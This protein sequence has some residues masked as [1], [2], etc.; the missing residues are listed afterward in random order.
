[1]K[2]SILEYHSEKKNSV[3]YDTRVED[4]VMFTA[5]VQ[6]TA[7]PKPWPKKIKVTVEVAE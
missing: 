5:Y 1:M 7:L 4:A 3:R 6:K 2:S